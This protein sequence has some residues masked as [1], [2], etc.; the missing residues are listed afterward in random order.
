MLCPFDWI[1]LLA[2]T[3]SFVGAWM[4]HF[5]LR[6]P[7]SMSGA[8]TSAAVR[9]ENLNAIPVSWLLANAVFAAAVFIHYL[10]DDTCSVDEPAFGLRTATA[11]WV[12][13]AA[14]ALIIQLRSLVAVIGLPE[15]F[16]IRMS[17]YYVV[18]VLL[19]AALATLVFVQA[20]RDGVSITLYA[21][22]AMFAAYGAYAICKIILVA[23][24]DIVRA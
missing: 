10:Y 12:L 24:C 11:T 3:V 8:N 22:A 20:A 17:L 18:L 1:A 13:I 5:A 16:A 9:R 4:P 2:I 7:Q 6:S 21:A 23:T 15:N 14:A 19:A